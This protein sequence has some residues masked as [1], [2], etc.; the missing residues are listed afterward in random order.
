V[1]A[2]TNRDLAA[3]GRR[4]LFRQ[5]LFFRLRVI[6]IELPALR[7]RREDIE[8]LTT[9]FLSVYS[10]RAGKRLTRVT[11]PVMEEFLRYAWPGNIREL[12]HVLESEVTMARNEQEVLEEVPLMMQQQPAEP[13]VTPPTPPEG[14]PAWP[15]P[16]WPGPQGAP[17]WP[18]S[19][20]PH[21]WPPPWQAGFAQGSQAPQPPPSIGGI[22]TV[23]ETER[24][25]LVAALTAHRGRIPEVARALGVSRG[26]VYNKMRKFQLAPE[27]FR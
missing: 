7:E 6:H 27:R 21:G 10:A 11:P 25:L 19:A 13:A 4:G 24:E 20:A 9:H 15:Y 22:K 8:F 23:E 14:W 26:T 12:E 18:P 17:G 2:T 5:D 3:E 16:W 1:L